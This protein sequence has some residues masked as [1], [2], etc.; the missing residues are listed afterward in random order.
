MIS[1]LVDDCFRVSL[2]RRCRIRQPLP[3]RTPKR[4]PHVASRIWI[5][6]VLPKP[7]DGPP[8]RDLVPIR[9]SWS[10]F[11]GTEQIFAQN[12]GAL[13]KRL[14]SVGPLKSQLDRISWAALATSCA[15]TV[16]RTKP[17]RGIGAF[18]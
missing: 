5:D 14:G 8:K 10:H 2:P 6:K 12:A 11:F 13:L 16:G 4:L 3:D 18:G 1:C 7:F 15:I 9:R 17:L